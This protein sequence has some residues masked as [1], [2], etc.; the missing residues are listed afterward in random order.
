VKFNSAVFRGDMS[1]VVSMISEGMQFL[2][3][4][5]DQITFLQMCGRV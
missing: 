4:E 2:K 5:A 1:E 3:E